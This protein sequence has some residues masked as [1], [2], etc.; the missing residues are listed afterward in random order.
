M[1][2][3]PAAQAPPVASG[4]GA[5]YSLKMGDL[6]GMVPPYATPEG[7]EWTIPMPSTDVGS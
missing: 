7:A 4:H 6:G 5:F 2:I 3:D 1:S